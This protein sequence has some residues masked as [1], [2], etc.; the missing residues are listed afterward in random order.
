MLALLFGSFFSCSRNVTLTRL[1]PAQI[2]VPTHVQRI[3]IINRT[4]PENR[5]FAILEGVLTGEMPFEVRNA[6]ESTINTVQGELNTSPRYEVV[7]A[8]ESL[9]GGFFSQTFPAPL[10]WEV[11]ESL[12]KK[13]DADAVLALEMFSSDFVVTDKKATIK[14]TVGTGTDAKVIEVPGI[15]AEGLASVKAGFRLYDRKS[16]TIADQQEFQQTNLWKAEAETKQQVMVLLISKANAT[17]YVGNMAGATYARRIAPM[18]LSIN[19]TFYHKSK[20]DPEVAIGAR[21]ADVNQWQSAIEVWER[22]LNLSSRKGGGRMAYNIAVGYE[23]L[24]DLQ[25]AHQ[26]AAHSFVHYGF[27][28]GRTYSQQLLRSMN[29]QEMLNRQ[30]GRVEN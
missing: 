7:R 11:I 13:Y 22:G 5:N 2:N 6:V 25:S 17:Q 19:R 4:L 18:Y 9:I 29:D 24:G 21:Y 23:V 28:N 15:Q 10:T 8:S 27:R 16:L 3:V 14:K 12:C 20:K 1:M 26:W 30:M